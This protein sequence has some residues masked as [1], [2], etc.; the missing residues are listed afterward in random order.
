MKPLWGVSELASLRGVIAD[1]LYRAAGLRD[2][3]LADPGP[4]TEIR[5]WEPLVTLIEDQGATGR[6]EAFSAAMLV[7][8][9]MREYIDRNLF[10]GNLTLDHARLHRGAWMLANPTKSP[11]DYSDQLGLPAGATLAFMRKVGVLPDRAVITDVGPTANEMWDALHD[12]PVQVF[13]IC[14]DGFSPDRL[15]DNGEVPAPINVPPLNG[16]AMLVT[17]QIAGRD[18]ARMD[19]LAN[20][21]G[22]DYG[23]K[24][25]VQS[26]HA[27][28]AWS[29]IAA[30]KKV[31]ISA[32]AARE[33]IERRKEW[34][35][36]IVRRDEG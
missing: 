27:I 10:A 26:H 25:W 3:A 24:G 8:C 2:L 32:E 18:F 34:E 9:L 6:C 22:K 5:K 13:V 20:T 36:W 1:P 21:W 14:H 12:S 17:A 30:P 4:F 16:H 19:V 7:E 31:E 15:K 28:L 23:F 29:F 35:G 33:W 11:E